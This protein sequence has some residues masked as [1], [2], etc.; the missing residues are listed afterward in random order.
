MPS[1]RTS[2]GADS[3][4]KRVKQPTRKGQAG[5][6]C[7]KRKSADSPQLPKPTDQH[8][9]GKSSDKDSQPKKV[10]KK[11][12]GLIKG[13]KEVNFKQL[14]FCIAYVNS[15]SDLKKTARVVGYSKYYA[16]KLLQM[17]KV[18]K[19]I[20]QLQ[21]RKAAR[22]SVTAEKVIDRLWEEA[23][24]TKA[25]PRD[26]NQALFHLGRHLGIFDGYRADVKEQASEDADKQSA[27]PPA[28]NVNITVRP[29]EEPELKV[30]EGGKVKKAASE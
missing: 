9:Q 1:S 23:T 3:N 2:N 29:K 27:A 18:K 12:N 11:R 17:G 5:K 19:K 21:E 16:E 30:L 14:D 26:R 24:N 22:S 4:K 10:K 15:G 20:L 28:L 13:A 25:A 7:K 6:V 8:K